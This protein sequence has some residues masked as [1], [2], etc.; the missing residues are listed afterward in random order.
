VISP[1]SACDLE[2]ASAQNKKRSLQRI[3]GWEFTFSS[4]LV[5]SKKNYLKTKFIKNKKKLIKKKKKLLQ[6]KNFKINIKNL[7]KTKNY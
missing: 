3:N 5:K 2:I 4:S 6:K 7:Q 1:V